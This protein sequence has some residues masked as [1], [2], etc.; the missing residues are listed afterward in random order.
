MGFLIIYYREE[1]PWAYW[2]VREVSEVV[3]T[4]RMRI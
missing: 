3:R 4:L 1:R 2:I